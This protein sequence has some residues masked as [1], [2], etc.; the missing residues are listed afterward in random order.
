ML[1]FTK[2]K[3]KIVYEQIFFRKQ[4]IYARRPLKNKNVLYL[5]IAMKVISLTRQ[6]YLQ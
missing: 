2:K 3:L 6:E 1:I 5:F 4:Q